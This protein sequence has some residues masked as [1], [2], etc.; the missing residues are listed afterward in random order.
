MKDNEMS[1][2]ADLSIEGATED[3]GKTKLGTASFDIDSST[4]KRDQIK[5]SI[6]VTEML[7]I[8]SIFL[9]NNVNSFRILYDIELII[10]WFVF[11]G[12]FVALQWWSSHCLS[13]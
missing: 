7:T 8:T 1:R 4:N 2:S 5:D 12:S 9:N 11:T 3:H 10:Q 13:Q 6:V